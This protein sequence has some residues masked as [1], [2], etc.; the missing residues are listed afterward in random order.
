MGEADEHEP[1]WD[2]IR[3][4]VDADRRATA[5]AKPR[6]ADARRR[7]EHKQR[8]GRVNHALLRGQS[9]PHDQR[10]TILCKPSHMRAV[11]ALAKELSQPRANVSIAALMDH[12]IELLLDKYSRGDLQEAGAQMPLAGGE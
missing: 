9:E 11:K 1:D 2:K 7:A 6:T 3:A 10:W 4:Q 12:A 5:G 8:K